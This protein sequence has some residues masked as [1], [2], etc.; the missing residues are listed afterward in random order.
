[1]TAMPMSATAMN[2]Q[3]SVSRYGTSGRT[4]DWVSDITSCATSTLGR[5]QR[6]H[7]GCPAAL[8][9]TAFSQ[10]LTRGRRFGCKS[11]LPG[12]EALAPLARGAEVNVHEPRARVEAEAKEPYLPRR[13]FEGHRIVVRHGDVEGRA[14]HVLRARRAANGAVVFWAAIGGPDD[15]R[16]AQPVAQRLKLVESE[17]FDKQLAGASACGRSPRIGVVSSDPPSAAQPTLQP[18]KDVWSAAK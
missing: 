16:L 9:G 18:Q 17:L 6:R 7:T 10:N 13:R 12:R 2:T 4:A 15:Q 3:R 1:M 11:R 14:I 8:H 5:T